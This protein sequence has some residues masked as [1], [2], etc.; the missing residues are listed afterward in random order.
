MSSWRRLY[1]SILTAF[2][3]RTLSSF[4]AEIPSFQ[5]I[6]RREGGF[7]FQ[8]AL[9][10]G[11]RE[12]VHF[13]S[14]LYIRWTVLHTARKCSKTNCRRAAATI[15]PAPLL[16]LW[17]PNRLALPS[18]P[19]LQCRPQRS[20]RF[21]RPIRSHAY[22]GL[23]TLTFDLLTLKVV[24]ESRVTWATSVPILVFLGLSVLDL[25]PM[26]ATDVRQTDVRQRR[27]LMPPPR[28]G[29]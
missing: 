17:A 10:N 19:C 29:A 13:R 6:S 4:D 16:P 8:L 28:G 11:S 14:V 23:V 5:H 2:L 27:R 24:S 1:F 21:P 15:C 12:R 26:Y 9:H 3:A 18:R 22:R 7:F 25:G 20:S